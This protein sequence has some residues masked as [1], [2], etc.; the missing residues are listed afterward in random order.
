MEKWNKCSPY[1]A[2]KQLPA[3][4]ILS[5]LLNISGL[6]DD[7]ATKPSSRTS[8]RQQSDVHATAAAM[9]IY[10]VEHDNNKLIADQQRRGPAVNVEYDVDVEANHSNRES[11]ED[12]NHHL[13]AARTAVV[14]SRTMMTQIINE[15][16]PKHMVVKGTTSGRTRKPPNT[17]YKPTA[18]HPNDIHGLITRFEMQRQNSRLVM[19]GD[20]SKCDEGENINE[21]NQQNH[22]TA[23]QPMESVYDSQESLFGSQVV[24]ARPACPIGRSSLV[25]GKRK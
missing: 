25:T 8:P 16:Q 10:G 24:D 22:R 23:N 18:I 2:L 21:E 12:I 14:P 3:C 15:K 13:R 6:N 4:G 1:R 17:P 19:K 20:A 5:S 7:K 11:D 9:A